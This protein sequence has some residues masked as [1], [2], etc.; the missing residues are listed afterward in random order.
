MLKYPV[1]SYIPTKVDK[2]YDLHT[3]LNKD[4]YDKILNDLDYH[5]ENCFVT[6]CS[7]VRIIHYTS[8]TLVKM[9]LLSQL[10]FHMLTLK[11]LTKLIRQL[12][13]NFVISNDH[14]SFH[15]W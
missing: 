9:M 10:F 11:A 5:F 15:L 12:V 3:R 13:Y 14:A 1:N 6:P 7:C 4:K 8:S 2:A